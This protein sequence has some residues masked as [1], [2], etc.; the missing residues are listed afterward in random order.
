MA[1]KESQPISQTRTCY[2]F[3]MGTMNEQASSTLC[4]SYDSSAEYVH[5]IN[6]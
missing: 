4:E 3:N 6:I 5:S 1:D 2:T